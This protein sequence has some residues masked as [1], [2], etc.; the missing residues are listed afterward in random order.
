MAPRPGPFQNVFI[1][2]EWDPRA[3]E[4]VDL[5]SWSRALARAENVRLLP[6]GGATNAPGS[7]IKADVR[8]GLSDIT[9]TLSISATAPAG[10][11]SPAALF[12][13]SAMSTGTLTAG[14]SSVVILTADLGQS[15][16][17]AA[18]DLFDIIGTWA[19]PSGVRVET[20][21]DGSTWTAFD[22]DK[23]LAAGNRTWRFALPPRAPRTIRHMRVSILNIPASPAGAVTLSGVRV[24]AE[25]ATY[26]PQRVRAFTAGANAVYE[27]VY[28]QFCIDVYDSTGWI[29]AA[30]SELTDNQIEIAEG[31][32]IET[33]SEAQAND[34]LLIF[35]K[36]K[37]E[38]RLGR[39]GAREW[40][41]RSAPFQNVPN[42]K[43]GSGSYTNDQPARWELTFVGA[44][45]ATGTPFTLRVDD[46]TTISIYYAASFTTTVPDI[47]TAL[48][49]LPNVNP[50]ITVTDTSTGSPLT[51]QCRIDFT[52]AGNEGDWPSVVADLPEATSGA[53]IVAQ[54]RISGK[55]GGEPIIS[56]SR[57]YSRCGTFWQQRTILGGLKSL[58]LTLLVSGSGDFYELDSGRSGADAPMVLP[59]SSPTDETVLRLFPGRHLLAFTDQGEHFFS[60]RAMSAEEPPNV[61][62]ASSV[63][64]AGNVPP[65]ET[66]NNV[67]FVG[68]ERAT[69][70]SLTYNDTKQSYDTLPL[71]LLSAH[72]LADI[73]DAAMEKAT[74]AVT[75]NVLHLVE[76]SG[77]MRAVTLMQSQNVTAFSRRTTPNGAY[78]SVCVNG[79]NEVIA[80]VE[81]T[82]NGAA[83]RFLERFDAA[84]LLDG[85]VSVNVT[86]SRTV[87]GL[88]RFEGAS[89]WA[90]SDVAVQGPL[91]VASGQ[92]TLDDEANGA[93]TVGYWARPDLR[94]LPIS[95]LVAQGVAQKKRHRVHCV[96]MSCHDTTHL[97]VG[98]P[99]KTLR[100]VPFQR[101]GEDIAAHELTLKRSGVFRAPGLLGWTD[102]GQVVISQ[103]R[104]GWFTLRSITLEK[105]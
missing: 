18:I 1:A 105:S 73:R 2:G 54:K 82:V 35:H 76:A 22:T 97:A 24:L 86:T 65:T 62:R 14:A 52:G 21:P 49:G 55:E 58:G 10:G 3:Y 67:L 31:S 26:G 12:S 75:S 45:W 40:D 42:H 74:T 101:F 29:A 36:D 38:A 43:F 8:G 89:V 27:L 17:V 63:G 77:E 66:E 56:A 60:E 71:S 53:A 61:V 23:S 92:I 79:R 34:T 87:T 28:S 81:R 59:I 11:S 13:F 33:F 72:I 94:P 20:S 95:S 99:G 44:G 102:S 50:G 104:P 51:P 16:A 46:D 37:A 85:A 78:K 48:E 83:R 84:Q 47:K 4:R 90:I 93:V 32:S 9:A 88:E 69:L 41:H 91:V 80:I 5:E 7:V 70:Y 15:V 68:R 30:R 39:Y 103:T 25:R 19:I 64:I 100:D 57:G 98:L 96:S 6:Q